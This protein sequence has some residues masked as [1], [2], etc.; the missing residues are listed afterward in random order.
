MQDYRMSNNRS[1]KCDVCGRAIVDP[2]G[3]CLDW[4]P[5]PVSTQFLLRHMSCRTSQ[6]GGYKY[7]N[8]ILGSGPGSLVTLFV[9]D[10][11]SPTG[12]PPYQLGSVPAW[13]D[14]FRRIFSPGYEEVREHLGS[15][16]ARERL[17]DGHV[18]Q[19]AGFW[20]AF[21]KALESQ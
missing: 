6:R 15:E 21:G 3:A 7:L 12:K 4:A 1:W 17:A 5:T 14:A 10:L 13:A 2:A 9:H 20:T 16:E 8:E 18:E 19:F 11:S